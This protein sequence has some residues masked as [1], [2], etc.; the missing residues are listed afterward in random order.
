MVKL[1]T[2]KEE[3]AVIEKSAQFVSNKYDEAN[4]AASTA[5]ETSKKIQEENL[6]LQAQ[7]EELGLA[8]D[9][10]ARYS[11]RNCLIISGIPELKKEDTDKIVIDIAKVNWLYIQLDIGKIDRTHR[12][13]VK[14]SQGMPRP[15]M[16]K[17][18]NYHDRERVYR[19]KRKIKGTKI[20]ITEHLTRSRYK[21]LKL[22][23]EAF[24][25]RNVWTL[26]GKIFT[27]KGVD[28]EGRRYLIQ[29]E[30]DIYKV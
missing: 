12:L 19:A 18:C 9:E 22:A 3:I 10:A 24:G 2:M 7:I 25:V 1:L 16:V 11:R 21:L 29:S 28:A 20:T 4:L 17:F 13:K 5:L 23:K 26:D 27:N 15:I 14:V 30:S 6:E 8:A